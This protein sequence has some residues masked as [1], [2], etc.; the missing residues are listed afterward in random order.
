MMY[1][2]STYSGS[3]QACDVEMTNVEFIMKSA[4]PVVTGNTNSSGMLS[5][6]NF[7][8]AKFK[9]T[10]AHRGLLNFDSGASH[11]ISVT[12]SGTTEMW[13]N[14]GNAGEEEYYAPNI[15]PIITTVAFGG[16]STGVTDPNTP[17][18][19]GYLQKQVALGKFVNY[20]TVPLRWK[21]PNDGTVSDG[22]T[23]ESIDVD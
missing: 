12:L 7:T 17:P 14:N 4:R 19:A 20:T 11:K 1:V 16:H 23:A 21:Y 15:V 3:P 8:D 10:K 13:N 2:T 9:W 5:T 18:L 22:T 6:V